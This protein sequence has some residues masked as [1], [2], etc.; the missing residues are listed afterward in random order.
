MTV[1]MNQL[2]PFDRA[3]TGDDT[4]VTWRDV[5]VPCISTLRQMAGTTEDEFL[6]I[7]SQMQSFYQ[8]S[9]EISQMAGQLVLVVSGDRLQ[10]LINRLQQMMT[11]METYLA[12]TRSRGTESCTTLK[13]VQELLDEVIHPLQGFQKMN[14]TLRMLSISTKIESSRLGELGSGFVNLA[15]DV[16]KLSHQVNDKSSDILTQRQT[17][18]SMIVSNLATVQDNENIQD[19]ELRVSLAATADNLNE[20]IAV[21]DRCTRFGEKVTTVS[22]DVITNISEVVASQQTHD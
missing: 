18:A 17:L 9:V 4:L 10:M 2:Q 11:D 3:Q 22:A 14:K 5:I 19:S 13:R 20:L 8:R 6:Q 15:M 1:A 16:E 12:D 7:G 21:N